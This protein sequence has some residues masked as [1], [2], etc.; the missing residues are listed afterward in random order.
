MMAQARSRGRT[1]RPGNTP[2]NGWLIFARP[3]QHWLFRL[4]GLIVRARAELTLITVT[5][6]VYNLA[7]DYYDPNRVLIGMGVVTIAIFAIPP[8]R[9]YVWRRFW[10]VITSSWLL[11]RS[12]S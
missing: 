10:C 5:V 1:R 11:A 8:S 3:E 7:T 9:R 4:L 2:H 12:S 6:T